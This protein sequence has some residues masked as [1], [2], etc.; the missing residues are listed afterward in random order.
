MT[1]FFSTFDGYVSVVH[2]VLTSLDVSV[3]ALVHSFDLTGSDARTTSK[4]RKI[5]EKILFKDATH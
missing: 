2:S 5:P 1:T 3:A 4:R